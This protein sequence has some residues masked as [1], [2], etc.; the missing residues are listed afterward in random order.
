M[1]RHQSSP[2]LSA[3][4]SCSSSGQAGFAALSFCSIVW[5]ECFLGIMNYLHFE[6]L[7]YWVEPMEFMIIRNFVMIFDFQQQIR[8]HEICEINCYWFSDCWMLRYPWINMLEYV[9]VDQGIG[10]TANRQPLP[11]RSDVAMATRDTVTWNQLR[12]KESFLLCSFL[13]TVCLWWTWVHIM[14]VFP[15]SCT[16]SCFIGFLCST[17]FIIN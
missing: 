2:L 10:R 16:F 8:S 3:E 17:K 1:R 14:N 4:P 5:T 13:Q 12:N 11:C 15:L 6:I 7:S 9:T